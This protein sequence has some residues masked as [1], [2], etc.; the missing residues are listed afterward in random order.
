MTE[1]ALAMPVTAKNSVLVRMAERFGVDAA[2][3]HATLKATAFK[4]EVSDAQFMA[5]MIVADQYKLNPLTKEIYAFPDKNSGIVPVVGVD[6]WAR[7]INEHPQFDGIEF[8]DGPLTKDGLPE[9]IEC[10]MYRKDRTHAVRVRE[11]MAECKRGTGPWGSH[12]RRLLRH[13]ATIQCARLAFGFVGIYDQDEA[14]RIVS[15]E[16]ISTTTTGAI[17]D[18]N[19]QVK[20]KPKPP[21]DETLGPTYAEVRQMIELAKDH[22]DLDAAV[23]MVDGLPEQF[24]PE[25]QEIARQR[26][27]K[28]GEE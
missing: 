7:I 27:A 19:A 23:S 20:A 14:E 16:V 8:A 6:G 2:K 11:Y 21:V 22:D 24:R 3:L 4:G 15:G 18:I 13:K 10:V 1:A 26:L 17:A 28:M 25:L 5:L 9:W 12:P